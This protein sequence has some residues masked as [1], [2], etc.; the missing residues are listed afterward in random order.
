MY[1]KEKKRKSMF[2]TRFTEQ[3]GIEH[4]IVCGGMTGLGTAPLI[5]AVANAGALGFL[6]ALTKPRQ[7][8]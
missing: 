6:T 3:F 7:R 4:P 8:H 2:R 5:S 1:P